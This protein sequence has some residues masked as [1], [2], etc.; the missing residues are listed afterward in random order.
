MTKELKEKP[1]PH[2]DELSNFDIYSLI[3]MANERV[4]LEDEYQNPTV[5]QKEFWDNLM[6]MVEQDPDIAFDVG[7][8]D[9]YDEKT[10][11]WFS[12]QMEEF[13]QENPDERP[14]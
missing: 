9:V 13:Y 4:K 11:D 7:D 8:L 5:A 14:M 2:F 1:C 6:Y 12:E 3:L 10:Q